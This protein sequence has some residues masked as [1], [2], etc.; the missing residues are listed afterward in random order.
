MSNEA[1]SIDKIRKKVTYTHELISAAYHESGHT[2]YGL[3]HHMKIEMVHVFEDKKT[4]RMCGFTHFN[5]SD[6]SEI[7]DSVLVLELMKAEICLNYSGLCAE[8][9][10]FKNVSG[11][12]K[13]PAFWKNGSSSDT[14]AAAELMKEYN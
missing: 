4:K 5:Y 1:E 8:K 14:M 9:Y 2:I 11:S 7:E 12:D 13:F 6:P 10:H 3:L